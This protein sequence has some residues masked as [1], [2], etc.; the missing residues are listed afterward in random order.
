MTGELPCLISDGT[1]RPHG[2]TAGHGDKG[3]TITTEWRR[4]EA[5]LSRRDRAAPAPWDKMAMLPYWLSPDSDFGL[6]P[7]AFFESF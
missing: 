6:T 7:A 5:I 2:P 1:S 3:A 4:A